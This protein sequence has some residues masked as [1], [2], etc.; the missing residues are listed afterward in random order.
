MGCR[1]RVPKQREPPNYKKSR[2][3]ENKTMCDL[4]WKCPYWYWNHNCENAMHIPDAEI[5]RL[6]T[7][8]SAQSSIPILGAHEIRIRRVL[9]RDT[10]D[11]PGT[12]GD[13]V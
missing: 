2:E 5:G 7:T 3:D 12:R 4:L 11:M 10:P 1:S 9:Y 13:V 6:Q 8:S